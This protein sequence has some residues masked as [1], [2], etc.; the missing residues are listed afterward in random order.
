MD[1]AIEPVSPGR[2]YYFA[3][4]NIVRPD[5]EAAA[6]TH[7]GTWAAVGV[8]ACRN[9]VGFSAYLG[10]TRVLGSLPFTAQPGSVVFADLPLPGE[11]LP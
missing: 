3:D 1:L 5:L 10:G 7:K 4:D 8:P 9:R 2:I 11:S 6:T